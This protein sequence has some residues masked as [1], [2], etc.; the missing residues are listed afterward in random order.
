MLIFT[1]KQKPEW[2]KMIKEIKIIA[3]KF[4]QKTL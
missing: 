4:K 2:E 3:E 1:G